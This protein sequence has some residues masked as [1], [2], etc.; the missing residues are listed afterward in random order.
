MYLTHRLA[1]IHHSHGMTARSK[2]FHETGSDTAAG[3][4][5]GTRC[6][7]VLATGSADPRLRE[8]A[9]STLVRAYWK[10]VYKYIRIVWKADADDARDLTQGFFTRALEASFFEGYDP[11]RA[12][13]RTYLRM[14]L[15]RWLVNEH[16]AA[17]RQKRGGAYRHVA[18]DFA[19]A[20]G[21]LHA[22]PD[23]SAADPDAFFRQ[24]TIRALFA[25]AVADLR[26]HCA[27]TGREG[28]FAVFER[29][30]LHPEE[31]GARPTYREIA[32]QLDLPVTQVTNYLAY[33]RR[34][35]RRFVLAHLHAMTGTDAEYRQEALELFGVDV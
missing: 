26:K 27:E 15:H 16:K 13:F 18:V 5:P 12:R 21:E 11:Q 35:L 24:E 30:D 23:A 1:A 17:K 22:L 8:D 6:S 3:A 31:R 34:E 14:V 9:W 2:S 19:G 32:E 10:P 20:E 4:F 28:H 25:L 7:V 29:Y 33:S